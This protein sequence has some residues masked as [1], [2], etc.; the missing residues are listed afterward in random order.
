[1]TENLERTVHD[2]RIRIDPTL[3]VSFG[4][5]VD[6][7]PEAFVLDEE[8]IVRFRDPATVSRNDLI[9]ACDV[10]PVDALMVWDTGGRQLVP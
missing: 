2:L 5:C 4:D 8:G 3:C 7:A 9:S 6:A 1:M 10:C